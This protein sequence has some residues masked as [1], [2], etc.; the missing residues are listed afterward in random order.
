[1]RILLVLHTLE[2]GGAPKFALDI[3]EKL[4]PDVTLRTLALRDGPLASRARSMGRLDI[5]DRLVDE[6]SR[7]NRIVS[8]PLRRALEASLSGWQPD[9]VYV[10]SVAS[11]PVAKFLRFPRAPVVLHVHELDSIFSIYAKKQ[12]EHL[13]KWPSRY[14]AV[15]QAVCEMLT[16]RYGIDSGKVELVYPFVDVKA[17]PVASHLDQDTRFVVGGAGLMDWRKG[18]ELWLATARELL[19]RL[20]SDKVRFVWLGVGEDESSWRFRDM[21]AKLH[22]E[23]AVEMLPVTSRPLN[24]FARFDILAM[25][26]WEDP[27]PRVV[28]E[29]MMLGKP[30]ACFSGSGGAAEV[31]GDTGLVVSEFS[32]RLMADQIEKLIKDPARCRE[33]GQAARARVESTFSESAQLP[34]IRRLLNA[35]TEGR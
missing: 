2:H 24:V 10:N 19:D 1:M 23:E 31:V 13:L 3:M 25:T 14:I 7:L 34:K 28:M 16:D 15:S 27:C 4:G 6:Y 35:V 11:I 26:S 33:L 21:V 29:T 32:G 20:G 12:P 17:P 5:I 9:V 30:V 8:P 18:P 22:L